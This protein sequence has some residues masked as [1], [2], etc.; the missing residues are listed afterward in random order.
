MDYQHEII[1]VNEKIPIKL[2]SFTAKNS[3][4]IIPKHWHQSLEIL[5]C[6]EGELNVWLNTEFYHLQKN[7][8]LVI[9]SNV[10]HSTQSPTKNQ[11]I[12][13]Q[14][15]LRFMQEITQEEY[16]ATFKI[17]CNTCQKATADQ[18]KKYGAIRHIL[19]EMLTFDARVDAVYKIKVIGLLYELNYLLIHFFRVERESNEAITTQKYLDRLSEIT[20][21]MK[22]NY[23][24]ELSLKRV[25]A[26]FNFSPPY[27]SRF[28]KK[29]M[30]ITY[31]D[32]LTSL[33][34]DEAYNLLMKTD[35]SII[36]ISYACGFPNIKSFANTFKKMYHVP[37]YRYRKQYK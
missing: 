5:Y 22:E 28:F 33:R 34:M 25:A 10:V 35:K 1:H 32:Y 23:R 2:F 12:V 4:R 21:F 13:L 29:Y 18:Q 37:P 31:L 30:G 15:P 8:L 26:T 3:E 11:V 16:L 20:L 19:N 36:E 27:F 24:E 6:L 7:D 14:I 17:V 9:N